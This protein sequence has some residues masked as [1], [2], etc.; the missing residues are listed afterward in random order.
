MRARA[1]RECAKGIR[2]AAK[3][4]PWLESIAA[5]SQWGKVNAELRRDV[6]LLFLVAA[7]HVEELAMQ[8]E[9]G[10][11]LQLRPKGSAKQ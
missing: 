4:V 8:F 7:D 2:L 6:R 10:R 1:L 3:D 9:T 5:K 11:P